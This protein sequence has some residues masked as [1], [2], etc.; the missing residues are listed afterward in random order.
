MIKGIKLWIKRI[1]TTLFGLYLLI[2]GANYLYHYTQ[3]T[4][5][6]LDQ[7][8]VG[9]EV[10][11]D[12]KVDYSI[13][14]YDPNEPTSVL[15]YCLLLGGKGMYVAVNRDNW[16]KLTQDRRMLTMMHEMGH[17]SMNLKHND[18]EFKDGC[19]VYLMA[20]YIMPQYCI[21]DHGIG[22]YLSSLSI[23]EKH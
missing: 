2:V 8:R 12:K 13:H 16:R 6:E 10:M 14:F 9:F 5:D 7:Y 15:A 23:Q 11:Y 22:Y 21:D 3:P 20:S 18:A 17:C 19:P 1:L 4:N